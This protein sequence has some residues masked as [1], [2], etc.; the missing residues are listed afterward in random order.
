MTASVPPKDT[1]VGVCPCSLLSSDKRLGRVTAAR[2]GVDCRTEVGSTGGQGWV[3]GAGVTGSPRLGAL[4]AFLRPLVPV[5]WGARSLR[6]AGGSRTSGGVGGVGGGAGPSEP[7][8]TTGACPEPGR[9]HQTHACG[10]HS[11]GASWAGGERGGGLPPV[12]LLKAVASFPG[13]IVKHRRLLW[14]IKF[15]EAISDPVVRDGVFSTPLS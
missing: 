6:R 11:P 10:W 3:P 5:Q 1:E 2:R 12:F 13:W 7:C 14:S 8:G 4:G 9:V 15:L